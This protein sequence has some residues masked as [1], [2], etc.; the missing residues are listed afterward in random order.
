MARL[1]VMGQYYDTG[2]V[3]HRM[4]P[5]AKVAT[6]TV[7]MF[8][9]LL[10][11]SPLQLALAAT[12]TLALIAA[13]RLG[14]GRVLGSIRSALMLLAVVGLL[15]LFFVRTGAV[16]LSAGPLVITNGGVVA[17]AL[18]TCRFALVCLHGAI[19]L[20]TT[21]PLDLSDAIESLMSPLARLGLPVSQVS[22]VLSLALR[23]V[24][25]LSRESR[26]ILDAQAARGAA[27]DA[28]G[29]LQRGRALL[30]SVVP[31]IAGTMR[32]ADALSRALDARCYEVG[33]P[34]TRARARTFGAQ[35]LALVALGAGWMTLLVVTGILGW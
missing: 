26:E 3:L 7:T 19:L 6:L 5:R 1:A 9:A 31:L 25:T 2:S 29:P 17:A 35:E 22:M 27:F 32:H 24:P 15:N 34:R 21:T 18:Y 33:A 20:M 28:G 14:L 12:G 30:A 13:S 11:H 23:F 10:V 16:L 8:G 4:D